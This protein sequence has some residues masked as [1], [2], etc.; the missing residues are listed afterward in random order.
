[1]A[2]NVSALS[3][4][5][6][7]KGELIKKAVV[8]VK[9]ISRPEIEF[10]AGIKYSEQF[11]TV[12]SAMAGQAGGCG[13]TTSG[14]TT[15][16]PVT[17]TVNTVQ[18]NETMCPE[19]LTQ[20]GLSKAMKPGIAGSE[21]LPVEEVFVNEKLDSL[22][23][24][25]E[26]MIWQG[27]T[28]GNNGEGAVTGNN[29]LANGILKAVFDASAST[30]N[31]TSTG[32]TSSNALQKVDTIEASIP[33]A[34]FGVLDYFFYVSPAYYSL[35]VQALRTA[36]LYNIPLDYNSQDGVKHASAANI[37]IVPVQGLAGS[38][39]GVLA[40]KGS[41]YVGTDLTSDFDEFKVWYSQDNNEVR[42]RAA[43]RIGTAIAF[44]DQIVRVK[45]A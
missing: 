14:T 22:G 17:L 34:A 10:R 11:T 23:S 24:I 27:A 6:D 28:S 9:T 32:W 15:L 43:F 38:S 18:F 2:F 21:E 13:W 8:N 26:K 35:Y 3:T 31:V 19:T 12:A 16:A 39:Y 41:I 29:T 5:T 36:N 44:A 25:M 33:A 45:L 30:V 42:T 1:M 40:P 4:Y 20:Y 37:T 7:N